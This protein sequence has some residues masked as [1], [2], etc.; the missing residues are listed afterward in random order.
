[1]SKVLVADWHLPMDG[2][3]RAESWPGS[4]RRNPLLTGVDLTDYLHKL[5]G[6]NA[7]QQESAGSGLDR[8]PDFYIAF[9]GC[10]HDD[11]SFGKFG[12]DC[13]QRIDPAQIRHAEVHKRNIGPVLTIL[14]NGLL[15]TGCL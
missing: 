6:R 4:G 2:L 13:E 12:S 9:K 7:L 3:L 10:E 11:A 5:V 15:P 1:M 8:A 14:L